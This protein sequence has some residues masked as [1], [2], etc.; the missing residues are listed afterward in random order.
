MHPVALSCSL[1]T[2]IH[3]ES[4]LLNRP[5]TIPVSVAK[6]LP[7]LSSFFPLSDGHDTAALRSPPTPGSLRDA[8]G[9]ACAWFLGPKAENADYFKISVETILNDVIQCRR[10]FAPEDEVCFR[11]V[12]DS[13]C[14]FS[15][16][17]RIS[18]TRKPSPRLR[19]RRAC[20]N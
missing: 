12:D 11:L 2:T 13:R 16:C 5:S 18:S 10:N 7:R 8:H 4:K 20:P 6:W 14:L 1:H 3:M 19:S 9:A 15:L 17:R